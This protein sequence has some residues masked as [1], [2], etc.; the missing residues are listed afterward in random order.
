MAQKGS[1]LRAG[2]HRGGDRCLSPH[3]RIAATQRPTPNLLE[4]GLGS[5]KPPS[6]ME[7][8]PLS[9]GKAEGRALASTGL[10]GGL[11][12]GEIST[13]ILGLNLSHFNP[14]ISDENPS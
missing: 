12:Q 3:G 10:R 7:A 4:R 9:T 5:R 13:L 14:L 2:G 6:S 11:Q 8:L 1:G